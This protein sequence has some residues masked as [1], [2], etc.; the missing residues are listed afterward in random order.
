[1]LIDGGGDPKIINSFEDYV[2]GLNNL[3]DSLK[4]KS[5][6]EEKRMFETI[7]EKADEA[8]HLEYKNIYRYWKSN[9]G[10]ILEITECI[11]HKKKSIFLPKEVI[12]IL[13]KETT[14]EQLKK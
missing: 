13:I 3:I 4:P 9:D 6:T 8:G 11:D 14:K 12:D 1:M 7:V 5:T 2:D 10:W